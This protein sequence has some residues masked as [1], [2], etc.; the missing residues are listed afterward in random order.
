LHHLGDA[1]CIV[2]GRRASAF[3]HFLTG[4]TTSAL[5]AHADVP[6]LCVPAG[7]PPEGR[8][9]LVGCGLDSFDHAADL[10]AVAFDQA[11]SR[12]ARLEVLHAWR[13]VDPYDVA[14]RGPVKTGRASD[15]VRDALSHYVERQP[16]S[17]VEWLVNAAYDRPAPALRELSSRAD[18]LVLGR[19]GHASPPFRHLGPVT[20]A[21]LRSAA[22]PVLVVP[23]EHRTSR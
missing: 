5:A 11:R 18:L 4:S 13:P 12:H 2:V 22:C 16:G 19:R 6:V 21:L 15:A 20:A 7:W 10:L 8:P 3:E 1:A 9:G 17:D 23:D 14:V